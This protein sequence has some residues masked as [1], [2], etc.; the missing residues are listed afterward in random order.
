VDALAAIESDQNRAEFVVLTNRG[1]DTAV[2][3]VKLK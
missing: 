2:R 3:R 1:S